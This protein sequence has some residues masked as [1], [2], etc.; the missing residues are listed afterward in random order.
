MKRQKGFTLIEWLIVLIIISIV[1]MLGISANQNKRREALLQNVRINHPEATEI[2][3]HT[4]ETTAT[5]YDVVT[6]QN[7]NGTKNT[8]KLERK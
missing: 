8:Y 2:V 3:S 5:S 4:V 7:K 1:I 6:V